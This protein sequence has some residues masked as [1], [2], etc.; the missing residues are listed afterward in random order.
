MDDVTLSGQYKEWSACVVGPWEGL[1]GTICHRLWPADC[2]TSTIENSVQCCIY[3]LTQVLTHDK[4]NQKKVKVTTT[5][6]STLKENKKNN[7]IT[8]KG[9]RCYKSRIYNLA[10][11]IQVTFTT[12]MLTHV[13]YIC[14]SICHMLGGKESPIQFG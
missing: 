5:Q 14:L 6:L 12:H 1:G 3:V 11:I 8:L 9:R 10:S 4:N 13:L 7:R 2:F